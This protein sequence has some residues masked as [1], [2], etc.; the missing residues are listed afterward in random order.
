ML[1][2]SNAS[3][4]AGCSGAV[5]TSRFSGVP[6]GFQLSEDP[7]GYIIQAFVGRRNK[8]QAEI[9]NGPA[10]VTGLTL[11]DNEIVLGCPADSTAPEGQCSDSTSVTVTTTAVDPENDVLTYNYTV[12]G[13]RITGTGA[14]VTWDLGGVQAGTYTI[15]SGV[16]D[17]CG[18]C[19]QTK[20]ETVKVVP[21]PNCVV[22]KICDCG[23]LSVSG[24]AGVTEPGSTMTFTANVSGGT[25]SNITYNWSVSS[26]TI[27]SG[28]GTPSITVATTQEMA[29]SSVTAT[30]ELGGQDPACNCPKMASETG[31]IAPKPLPV[32]VD[33]FGKLSNDDV[34]AKLDAFFIELQ[35]NP[36]NQGYINN[37]G[38]AKDIADRKSVV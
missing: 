12:S 16:D 2:R 21:C 3:G 32:L 31:S 30:V 17:G 24:P 22:K 9:L 8:R 35:N 1:F 25:S 14:N 28:Q 5:I 7:H 37:Y 18:L 11:S 20:T 26:G 33:E 27:E 15:T 38:S 6:P 19:G 36:N 10:N 4:N 13:G 29:N 34:K 23:T